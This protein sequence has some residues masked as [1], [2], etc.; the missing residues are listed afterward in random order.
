M[1]KKWFAA[2][3]L[4]SLLG[5]GAAASPARA[6]TVQG[7]P[8]Q[9]LCLYQA[10]G[11]AQ[12][13][14]QTSLNNVYQHTNMCLNIPNAQWSNGTP[15]ADNAGSLVVNNNDPASPWIYYNVYVHNWAN[16]NGGGG[17]RLFQPSVQQVAY[18]SAM[19][20]IPDTGQALYHTIT[21][22]ELIPRP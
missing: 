2:A 6:A 3:L 19:P 1:I 5:V 22:V 13:R 7:C 16:C 8:G 10:Q 20:Y 18:L 12:E 9:S 4:V 14:W 17:Y 21:S 15:V 11:F